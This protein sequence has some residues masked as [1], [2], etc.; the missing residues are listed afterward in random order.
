[1]SRGI[2]SGGFC[3]GGFCPGGFCPR[4]QKNIIVGGG[5][6]SIRERIRNGPKLTNWCIFYELLRESKISIV[7]TKTVP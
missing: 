6:N 7:Q 4:T 1:M 3:P 2:L 5:F